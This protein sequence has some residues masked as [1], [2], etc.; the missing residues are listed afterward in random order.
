MGAEV[1]RGGLVDREM[2]ESRTIP[3]T[4]VGGVGHPVSPSPSDN[5]SDR[6]SLAKGYQ[7]CPPVL[8]LASS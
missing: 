2:G 8:L 1:G 7:F 4:R 6:F 5:E 3:E